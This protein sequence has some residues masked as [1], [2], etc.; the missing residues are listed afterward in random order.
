ML[1]HKIYPVTYVGGTLGSSLGF[2]I[3]LHE[4]FYPIMPNF[5]LAKDG[6]VGRQLEG[7]INI[8]H[9]VNYINKQLEYVPTNKKVSCRFNSWRRVEGPSD[10]RDDHRKIPAVLQKY[11]G[12]S[13]HPIM[14]D[15][16]EELLNMAKKRMLGSNKIC[17]R[18]VG[19][20][21]DKLD[22][23]VVEMKMDPK[24]M[25]NLMDK[26]PDDSYFVVDILKLY[27]DYDDN[28][29][30]KLCKFVDTQP[31]AD[32]KEGIASIKRLVDF[33]EWY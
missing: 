14:I 7:I 22:Q 2:F 19:E 26:L 5:E 21:A 15:P 30:E 20:R 13:I 1:T 29:Y 3:S 11:V 9:T 27:K 17:A 33:D 6:N 28:E 4:G 24:A 16:N 18:L 23:G 10:K 31:R 8:N 32:W 12:E 25:Y